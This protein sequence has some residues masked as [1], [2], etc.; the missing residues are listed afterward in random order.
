LRLIEDDEP[1]LSLGRPYD[2]FDDINRSMTDWS[3]LGG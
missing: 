1:D 3:G 2:L